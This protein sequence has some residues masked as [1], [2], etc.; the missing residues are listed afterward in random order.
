[1][2]RFIFFITMFCLLQVNVNA[3]TLYN[4]ARNEGCP[5]FYYIP[6]V[7]TE[8][9]DGVSDLYTIEEKYYGVSF[10]FF[11]SNFSVCKQFDVLQNDSVSF[12]V[13]DFVAADYNKATH[14]D[15]YSA[16]P[17]TKTTFNDDAKIEY[18]RTI[19]YPDTEICKRIEIVNED[20][21]ILFTI[22]TIADCD[23]YEFIIIEYRRKHFFVVLGFA[24]GK[25]E[26]GYDVYAIN[27]TG[28]ESSISKVNSLSGISA[29]PVFANRNSVV[30]VTIAEAEAANG[31][32]LVIVDNSGRVVAT[33][34]F[35]PGQ[36]TV[37]VQT[38]RMRGGVYNITL[39]NGTEIENARIIVK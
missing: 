18:V 30:N 25:T 23:T 36:T 29:S 24:D 8:Y 34:Q 15:D 10:T 12:C 9:S 13:V 3:Q 38:S 22:P 20:N 5:R 33:Q 32:E 28:I 6:A 14:G 4:V 21:R 26:M 7:P 31:G 11:D 37:P 1:M 2:K 39:N 16:L 19:S 35:E 17:L 27:K